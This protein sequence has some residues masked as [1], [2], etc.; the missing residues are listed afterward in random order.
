[1][2][3]IYPLKGKIQHYA[4]GGYT[5]IPSMLQL[6]NNEQQPFAEYWLGAHPNH[7]SILKDGE[8]KD[9]PL[10]DFISTHPQVLSETTNYNSL[11]FLLKVLDVRQM[12]SIQ[13][14]PAKADAAAAFQ[15]E[16]EAGIPM[17]AA[18]RNYKDTNHKPEM[19]VALS[20]FWLLHGFKSD[21]GIQDVLKMTPELS[22]L[23]EQVSPFTIKDLF[24][25]IMTMPQEA[26]DR[27]V[28]QLSDRIMP[29]YDNEQLPK[30]TED[31]W[32]ARAIKTYCNDNQ[33][34]KGVLAI[35]T[36]NLVHLQEG[37]GIFQPSGMPHAYLEG[38]NVEIMANSD[39]V[40]RAGLTDKHIDVEEL[41]KHVVFEPTI[42]AI[43]QPGPDSR[44][45]SAAEEF[46]LYKYDLNAGDNM[47]LRATDA[48]VLLVLS[49]KVTILAGDEEVELECGK[50]VFIAAGTH[51]FLQTTATARVF[52]A[53][54]GGV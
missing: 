25:Y 4:W 3:S 2:Q 18:H 1:M 21:T 17:D 15:A 50:S 24:H 53:T 54:I 12:L 29:L 38:Q 36:L 19:M 52:K 16:E 45:K 37:E 22:A 51:F 14:H 10:N 42:P 41:L 20:S 28:K 7:P 9:W 34:D 44:Y 33:Y 48:M 31:F 47:M 13:V 49:G 35:Y 11:P 6:E 40:L 39:N 46:A 5:Y 32:A 43:L 8:K 30:E 27:I 26:I 23:T